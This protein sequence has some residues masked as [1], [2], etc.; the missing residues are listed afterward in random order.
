[1]VVIV[2]LLPY[3]I[4]SVK[5][6]VK[7]MQALSHYFPHDELC[8]D[9]MEMHMHT[10]LPYLLSLLYA[11]KAMVEYIHTLSPYLL[12]MFGL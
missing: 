8:C 6:M 3:H 9:A 2:A 12:I 7:H 4:W 10:S 1:M 5:A 11:V